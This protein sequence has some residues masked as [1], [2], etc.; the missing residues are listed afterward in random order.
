MTTVRKKKKKDDFE[1]RVDEYL[2][3]L[4]VHTQF[5]TIV[6]NQ[7]KT[8]PSEH[9][10]VFTGSHFFPICFALLSARLVLHYCRRFTT[11]I[12]S[13]KPTATRAL[14]TNVD[15]RICLK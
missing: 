11:M 4:F 9:E 6:N 15:S 1:K 10:E 5:I 12:K 2:N 14:S 3:S 7:K 8:L 13:E